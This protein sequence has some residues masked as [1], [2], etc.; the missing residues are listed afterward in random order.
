MDRIGEYSESFTIVSSHDAFVAETY[1]NI[2]D[3]ELPFNYTLCDV[4]FDN[5]NL[6]C[7]A[8]CA[9]CEN[10]MH[11]KHVQDKK[12][13]YCREC[14]PVQEN[15][16]KEEAITEAVKLK[17]TKAEVQQKQQEHQQQKRVEQ[18]TAWGLPSKQQIQNLA[19]R[20]HDLPPD[21]NSWPELGRFKSAQH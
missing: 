12:T 13:H 20:L 5:Q 2:D 11:D 10:I 1:I 16:S 4:C 19:E 14:V 18:M 17:K 6:P 9:L 7:G 15:Q 3:D 8:T 21:I